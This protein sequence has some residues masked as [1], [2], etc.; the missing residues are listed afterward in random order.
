MLKSRQSTRGPAAAKP[1]DVA[2]SHWSADF[3]LLSTTQ[4][5]GFTLYLQTAAVT[6]VAV[7]RMVSRHSSHTQPVAVWEASQEEVASHVHVLAIGRHGLGF[8]TNRP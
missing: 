6:N 5:G 2:P 7:S 1:C 4:S 3:L 8:R